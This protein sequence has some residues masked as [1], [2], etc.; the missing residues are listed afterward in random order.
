MTESEYVLKTKK[1]FIPILM[2]HS[3][4]PDGWLGIMIGARLYFDFSGKYDF[5]SKANELLRQLGKEPDKLKENDSISKNSSSENSLN[6]WK[7]EDI[8]KW[9]DSNKLE[10]L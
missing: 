3:Y 2:E 6:N 7:K 8:K 5:E 10:N 4:Q 1:H 9:V